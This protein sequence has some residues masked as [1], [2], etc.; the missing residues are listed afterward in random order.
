MASLALGGNLLWLVFHLDIWIEGCTTLERQPEK[1]GMQTMFTG[2][3]Q[4]W[5]MFY[6]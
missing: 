6:S 3:E 2:G 4:T 5:L 1:S